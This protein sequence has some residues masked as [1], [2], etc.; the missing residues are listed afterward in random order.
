MAYPERQAEIVAAGAR[1]F[2]RL[3]YQRAT[4][5]EVAREAGISLAGL[6]YYAPCKEELLHRIASG[7]LAAIQR[8]VERLALENLGSEA[9]LRRLILLHLEFFAHRMAEMKVLSHES[10]FLFGERGAELAERKRGYY[11]AVRSLLA[12]LRPDLGDGQLRIGALAL[13]GMMNWLYT[14][15]RPELDGPAE[16]VAEAMAEIFLHGWSRS[17]GGPDRPAGARRPELEHV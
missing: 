7:T 17:A 1:V 15:Y 13:L 11:Q 14:W 5:R 3:G 12:E 6:Y 4:L 10:E 16:R 8:R 2:A 9:R